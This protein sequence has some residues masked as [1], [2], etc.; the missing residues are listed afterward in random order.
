MSISDNSS[1]MG[2]VEMTQKEWA[3]PPAFASQ[4]K[5]GVSCCS[6]ATLHETQAA[7]AAVSRSVTRIRGCLSLLRLEPAAKHGSHAVSAI[8]ARSR[9]AQAR[10][11]P[12][13]TLVCPPTVRAARG[14]AKRRHRKRNRGVATWSRCSLSDRRHSNAKARSSGDVWFGSHLVGCRGVRLSCPLVRKRESKRMRCDE[15]VGGVAWQRIRDRRR[16]RA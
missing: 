15:Q 3:I 1:A 13:R 14:H 6:A 7:G 9:N 2:R 8:Q 11:R 12:W 5:S 10:C 4:D 16:V